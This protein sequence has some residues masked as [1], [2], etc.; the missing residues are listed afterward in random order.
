MQIHIHGNGV[1]R[2]FFHLVLAG[3]YLNILRSSFYLH[4]NLAV[5]ILTFSFSLLNHLKPP[6][7]HHKKF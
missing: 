3:C 2:F 1:K 7:Y 6:F 5:M 4:A